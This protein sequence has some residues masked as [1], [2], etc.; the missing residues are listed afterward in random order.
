MRVVTRPFKFKPNPN[1]KGKQTTSVENTPNSRRGECYNCGSKDHY[2]NKCPK[3]ISCRYCKSSGHTISLCPKLQSKKEGKLNVAQAPSNTSR[4]QGISH[5]ILDGI[6]IFREFPIRVLF[7]MG[8]S[9]SFI[10]KE[11]VYAL[12]LNVIGLMTSLRI[13]N[14][15]GGSATLSLLCKDVEIILCDYAFRA[16]LHVMRYLGFGMILGMDWLNCYEAQ[17]LRPERTIH[18]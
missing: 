8:A 10:S 12:S 6:I 2:A 4:G 13:A 9:H 3:S 15:V 18:L 7:D 17:I 1:K 16:G 11:L 14:P 5:S